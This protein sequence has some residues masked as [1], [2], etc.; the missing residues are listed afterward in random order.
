MYV[1]S[2]PLVKIYFSI[3]KNIKKTHSL[4]RVNAQKTNKIRVPRIAICPG[5]NDRRLANNTGVK[6][7][8]CKML[9]QDFQ[10]DF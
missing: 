1:F 2:T 10:S 5:W 6:Q 9:N 8:G 7:V 4:A 3:E